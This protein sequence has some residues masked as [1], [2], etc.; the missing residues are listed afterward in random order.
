MSRRKRPDRKKLTRR[1]R[2]HP[3]VNPPE[4]AFPPLLPDLF[5]VVDDELAMWTDEQGLHALVPGRPAPD[6][7]QR[8]TELYQQKI[9]NSPLWDQMV[10]EFGLEKAE[11][12]LQEFRAQPG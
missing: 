11:Q 10:S 1:R 5:G 12:L 9:R 2:P 3:A 8:L 4:A 7:F 6:T